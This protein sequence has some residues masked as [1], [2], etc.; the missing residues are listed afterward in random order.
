MEKLIPFKAIKKPVP[1]MLAWKYG[2]P[3]ATFA[4]LLS[5][6]WIAYSSFF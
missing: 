2:A 3:A 1:L 5:I 4:S 6:G